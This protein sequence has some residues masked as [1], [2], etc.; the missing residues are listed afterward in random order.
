MFIVENSTKTEL[1]LMSCATKR[2]NLG[3]RALYDYLLS[4]QRV[5]RQEFVQYIQRFE[6]ANTIIA[7]ENVNWIEM[8]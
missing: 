8:L 5:T 7:E 4:L 3:D 1:Q 2:H 6:N